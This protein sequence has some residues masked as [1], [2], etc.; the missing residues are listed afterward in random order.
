MSLNCYRELEV[1]RLGI[2]LTK[3]VYEL[4]RTFPKHELYAL[5]NQM[6]RAAVSVPANIA[7]GHARSSTKEFLHHLSI[8]RGSLAEL[9]TML[10][11]AEELQ[12]CRSSTTSPILKLCDRVSR[13]IAGLMHSLNARIKRNAMKKD[14]RGV[15]DK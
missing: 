14:E 5:C 12:Y 8:A 4:T 6:Q 3:Q 15:R 11:I 1:W 2:A 13:M 10:T 9:E 7:E